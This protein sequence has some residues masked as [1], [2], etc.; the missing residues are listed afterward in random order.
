MTQTIIHRKKVTDNYS[1]IHNELLRRA[2]L[3]WKA[4]GIMCYLLS[5]P[6]DWIIYLDELVKHA[7]D[8]RDSF[9]SGWKELQR[10]GYV[11]RYPVKEKGKIIE[12][13][14]EVL[15]V[16][17]KS[18]VS[19]ETEPLEEKPPLVLSQVEKPCKENPTL[20]STKGTKDLSK[21]KTKETK[22]EA[23]SL[24]SP[25]C[26][27]WQECYGELTSFTRHQLI[28]LSDKY[29]EDLVMYALEET[30]SRQIKKNYVLTYMKRILTSFEQA[31]VT[32]TQQAKEYQVERNKPKPF[33]EKARQQGGKTLRRETLPS[34]AYE[35]LSETELSSEEKQ[36][37]LAELM[38]L[39]Q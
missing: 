26:K 14:T 17:E 35:T 12:W 23:S 30:A 21:Q 29:G 10:K 32:T 6:S 1:I 25:I 13:R 7:S 8:G 11:K 20:L 9:R 31:A 28:S 37:I 19:D 22:E 5:L 4:K 2:D 36:V 18:V 34:W 16:A 15:E 27:K 39:R 24:L 38:A 33:K 3:S